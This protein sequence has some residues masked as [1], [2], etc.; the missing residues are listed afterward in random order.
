MLTIKAIHQ[1]NLETIYHFLHDLNSENGFENPYFGVSFED[2]KN[3]F[4][5]ELLRSSR[6]I[7]PR[8][9]YV[10]NTYY[11]LWYQDQI[12][13]LFKVR[14]FLNDKLRYGSG[15]IGYSIHPKFRGK[16]FATE[17]LRLVIHEI[18]DWILEDE[19]YFSSNKDNPASLK[20]QLANGAYI[21]HTDD[22]HNY[23]RIK[24]R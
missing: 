5:I 22:L 14:H 21:H 2:F 24:I 10:P 8:V 19:L 12:I 13:G 7:E 15:H 16:G 4:F 9:G 1:D 3:K 11:F 20:V 6:G 23:A 17:G 18:K